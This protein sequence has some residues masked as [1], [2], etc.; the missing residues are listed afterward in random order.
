MASSG[1]EMLLQWPSDGYDHLAAQP[2]PRELEV[3]GLI[4]EG[5]SLKD[6]ADA[7]HISIKTVACHRSR[8]L[9]KSGAKNSIQLFRWAHNN[10][11]VRLEGVQP[12]LNRFP[13]RADS[14]L[15]PLP[16]LQTRQLSVV[17]PSRRF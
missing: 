14:D 15:A 17:D 8:L 6:I 12:R 16:L 5:Y 11:Y 13:T 4:C 10:G 2:T 9:G 1:A 3:L 7:L